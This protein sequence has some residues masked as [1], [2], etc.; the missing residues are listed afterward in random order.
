MIRFFRTIRQSLLAQGRVTRYLSYAIGEIVLVVIGILVALQLNA[1]KDLRKA[2]ST[3]L[4]YLQNIKSDLLAN[5]AKAED[6][7]ATRKGCIEAAQRIIAKINGDPITDW[8]AFTEDRVAI[9]DWKRYYPI[10]YTV[11][12]LMN[13]GGLAL[14]TNDSVKTTLLVLESLYKQTKAEEDHFRFD[15]EELI[16]KPAYEMMDLEPLLKQHMGA[17]VVM[18]RKTYDAFFSDFRTKNGF[19]MVLI[20]FSTMNGQLKEIRT[21][22]EGLIALIDREIERL[23]HAGASSTQR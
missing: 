5:T 13:S 18:D 6:F 11:Q 9:Y 14:L 8:P 17:E 15:S 1:N 21:I 20:E 10:N 3:E 4:N 23:E 22:S 7:I 19:L 16:Y 12:E 2:R